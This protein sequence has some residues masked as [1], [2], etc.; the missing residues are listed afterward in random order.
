MMYDIAMK[1]ILLC[2]VFLAPFG[3]F[4]Q[5]EVP[6]L[7]SYVRAKVLSVSPE[8]QDTDYG[9]I[10]RSTQDVQLRIMDGTDAGTVITI[11]NSIL[12]DRD[13][14]RLHEG[15]TIIMERIISPDGSTDY[16]MRE[17]Y[18]LP[19]LFVLTL[20][21]FVLGVLL[22]GRVGFTSILGLAVSVV[23]L[24]FFVVPKI[25][26]GSNPLFISLVGS[27]GIA[28]TSLYLAHGWNR[29]TT[30]AL[31][32][33]IITLFLSTILAVVFVH[34][35]KLFGM[36][37]EESVFLQFGVL[38]QV[39]L[40][41]LLLGGIIIG[42]LGVLDDITTAQTAAIDE[43]SKANHTLGFAELYHAGT[44]IGREHI[45]SLINTLA[46]AYVGA[47]LPILLLFSINEEMPW[48][49][50]VNSE[51]VAEEIVRTLVGSSTLLLAVPIS[52]WIAAKS[53]ADGNHTTAKG[54]SHAH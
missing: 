13:D 34:F 29:R 19:S 33:T 23:I 15:E 54:H 44:S 36:G 11:E 48:W 2:A 4:A 14:M 35:A 41:G 17:K 28:F 50:I 18:R 31:I 39:N 38:E 46:L 42:A 9:G 16:L 51:F 22:A 40:R 49:V 10:L 24:I 30:I 5:M 12:N 27:V 26:A 45:A 37:T 20:F 43:L 25:I 3:A 21:F 8:K 47:S 32:S 7:D 52:T 6:V 53:F 1:Y